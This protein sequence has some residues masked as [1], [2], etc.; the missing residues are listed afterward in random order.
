[1]SAETDRRPVRFYETVAVDERAEG[2]VVLLDGAPLKTPQARVLLA[3]TKALAGLV[4]QEWTA[5]GERIDAATMPVTALLAAVSDR[6]EDERRRFT[7][8]VIRH[9]DTDVVCHV[10]DADPELARR[11]EA[12]WAPLRRWAAE[13]LGVT[14]NPAVG[15]IATSQ[16]RESY[17]A[18]A[19]RLARLDDVTLAALGV[20]TLLLGSAVLAF[21]MLERRLD[22]AEALAA[23]RI[24]E[25]HQ[26]ERWGL[27]P[28][29]VARVERKAA[30]LATLERVM[31]AAVK[32]AH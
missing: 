9:L 6:G 28:E 29:A 10:S 14:L 19:A 12:I 26:A 5:Q 1:M 18:A 21:A 13:T 25:I 11:E 3:A 23:S 8:D 22:A 7:S 2:F 24:E 17:E 32:S 20:S 31:R 15:V 30:E 16:P 27:V 4:A